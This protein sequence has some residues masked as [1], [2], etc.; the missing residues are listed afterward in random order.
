MGAQRVVWVT[1]AGSGM[2]RA[3]ARRLAA[4]GFAVALSGRR[5]EALVAVRDEIRAAGGSALD[6]PLDVADAAAVRAARERIEGDL[7]DVTDAV[8]AAG[9]NA[10][11]RAWADLTPDESARIVATNLTGSLTVAHEILPT[12]RRRG[13]GTIVFVSSRAGWRFASLAGVAY[14]ASK[15]AVGSLVESL[16]DEENV[17]GIRACHLC[18]G[19]V[20]SDFLDLRPSV[21]DAAARADM[22]TAEDIAD[23]VEFVLTAP[24]RV[25]V[26]ELVVTPVKK[27][28]A[29]P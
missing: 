29:R 16:N 8:L 24:G 4:R 10:P 3:S 22:L 23:S 20:D 14:S 17:H 6:V 28:R 18:P 21:P 2:G 19:D 1:G 5:P 26:N 7:G 9:L 15:T 12:M 27:G 13:E 25:C 11:H